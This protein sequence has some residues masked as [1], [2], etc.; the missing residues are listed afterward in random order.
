V[1]A[2]SRSN[3]R[4]GRRREREGGASLAFAVVVAFA[5]APLLD[6]CG[7]RH[8]VIAPDNV[9]RANDHAWKITSEPG[10]ASALPPTTPPAPP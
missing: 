3:G 1:S 5:L 10:A 7:S 8:V 2:A 6:G 4:G 9:I